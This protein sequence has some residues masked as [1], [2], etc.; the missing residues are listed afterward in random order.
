[1]RELENYRELGEFSKVKEQLDR[2]S[3]TSYELKKLKIKLNE[4][5]KLS[6]K[7]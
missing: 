7:S 4:I 1:M 2:A 3:A 6:E 5:A